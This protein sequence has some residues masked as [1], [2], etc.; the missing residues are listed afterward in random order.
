M[1]ARNDIFNIDPSKVLQIR[2]LQQKTKRKHSGRMHTVL[3]VTQ[4]LR[5]IHVLCDG[6]SHSPHSKKMFIYYLQ[7]TKRL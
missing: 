3:T 5:H 4:M 2:S 6:E 7:L 1:S